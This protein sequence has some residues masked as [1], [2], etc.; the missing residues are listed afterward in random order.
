MKRVVRSF[1]CEVN[2]VTF[3]SD[4]MTASETQTWFSDLV[5]LT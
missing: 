2:I 1:C 5:L 4:L 3:T